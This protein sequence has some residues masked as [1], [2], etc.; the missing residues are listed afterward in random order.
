M[1]GPWDTPRR[2]LRSTS[3][4]RRMQTPEGLLAFCIFSVD[5]MTF[6][7]CSGERVLRRSTTPSARPLSWMNIWSRCSTGATSFILLVMTPLRF[8]VFSRFKGDLITCSRCSSLSRYSASMTQGSRLLAATNSSAEGSGPEASCARSWPPPPAAQDSAAGAASITWP[9]FCQA[10]AAAAAVKCG[11]G[12]GA[13]SAIS[14][15]DA[16]ASRG[17]QARDALLP[18]A[19]SRASR[20]PLH[21]LQVDGLHVERDRTPSSG[22]SLSSASVEPHCRSTER[23]PDS[24]SSCATLRTASLSQS[25]RREPFSTPGS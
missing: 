17:S 15:R 21:C 22:M 2:S 4:M 5:S 6:S 20:A 16:G 7:C 18:M 19:L 14:S 9:A 25:Y 8:V 3:V 1:W 13:A 23:M 11:A 12:A 10:S 24:A